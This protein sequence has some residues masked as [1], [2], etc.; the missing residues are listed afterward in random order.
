LSPLEALAV[1]LAGMAAG[2]INAVVGS[3]TLVT[4]PVLLAIGIAP[5]TANISNTIGLVPGSISAVYGYRRELQGQRAR[6]VRYGIASLIGGTGG[7]ALLFLLPDEAFEAIVPAMIGIALLLVVFQ[8]RIARWLARRQRARPAREG[9]A[10]STIATV[11]SGLYGGYFGAGQGI[12]LLA[13]LGLA[14][15]EEL[16]RVVALKNVLAMLVNLIA[17]VVFVVVGGVDWLVV[18]VIAAGS[19][20]GGLIGAR[21]GRLLPVAALRGLIVVVGIVAMAQLLT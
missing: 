21:V 14:L 5:V 16:H 15:E 12:L 13:I 20:A 17:G 1:L 10:P 3:G 2:T 4:F 11:G 19:S 7:A 18:V 9:G 6:I 8:P